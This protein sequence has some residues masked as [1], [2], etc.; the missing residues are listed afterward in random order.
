MHYSMVVYQ[1][2]DFSNLKPAQFFCE[3]GCGS[4]VE[5]G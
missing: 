5:F 1:A 4:G 2:G 3:M